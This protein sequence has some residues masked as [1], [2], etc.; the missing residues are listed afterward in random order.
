MRLGAAFA[1]KEW[2]VNAV[3]A[4]SLACALEPGN[5]QANERRT[6]SASAARR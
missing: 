5:A 6:A 4:F 1:E 2:H 3:A